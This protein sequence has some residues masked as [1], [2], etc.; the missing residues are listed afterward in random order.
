M[1]H[2]CE[3]MLLSKDEALEANNPCRHARQ[4]LLICEKFFDQSG[5]PFA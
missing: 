2:L 3:E 4:F 1:G 5:T